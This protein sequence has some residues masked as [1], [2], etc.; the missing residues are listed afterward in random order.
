MYQSLIFKKMK[1]NLVII[2]VSILAI[3]S[4]AVTSLLID[5]SLKENLV[6]RTKTIASL[7][8]TLP[9]NQLQGDESDLNN[10]NYIT[11]KEKLADLHAINKD[12][13][14]IYLLKKT[15]KGIIFLVDSESAQSRDYSPPGQLYDEASPQFRDAIDYGLSGWEIS[16]DRWGLWITGYAPLYDPQTGELLALVGVDLDY[17]TNYLLPIIGYSLLPFFTFVIII[18]IMFYSE[19]LQKIEQKIILEKDQ[20]IR[21]AHH[22]IGTPVAETGWACESLLDNE[23]IKHDEKLLPLTQQMYISLMTLVRRTSNLLK[24]IELTVPQALKHE[25]IDIVLLIQ[26]AMNSHKKLAHVK[27]KQLTILKTMPSQAMTKG[28]TASLQVVFDSLIAHSLYYAKEHKSVEITYK[29][30]TEFHIFTA[31]SIGDSLKPEEINTLFSAYYKGE[32]LSN[33]TQS[34]GLGLY[35]IHKIVT[36]YHG[37]V[38]A[39]SNTDGV[40]I[41][42][43]LPKI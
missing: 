1:E 23:T 41:S 34:T 32:Q 30:D 24:T 20:L 3:I 28:D 17:Y 10:P 27:D 9:T 4:V 13:R 2:S 29:D 15:D 43:S 22:E 31:I 8:N 42:V 5:G 12:S 6:T 40:A 14:F 11:Y 7:L 19:K 16:A 39:S 26:K 21:I 33:H 36:L 18:V 37:T 25:D 35:L 38:S